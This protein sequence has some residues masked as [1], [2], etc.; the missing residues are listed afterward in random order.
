MTDEPF[1]AGAI[2]ALGEVLITRELARRPARAPDPAAEA[3]TLGTLARSLANEPAGS[4]RAVADAALLL[5]RAEAAVVEI[6]EQGFDGG[7][8]RR[9]AV[10]GAVRPPL[11]DRI[12]VEASR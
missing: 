10:A 2:D 1:D 5:C 12:P 3:R 11:T 8:V 6:G 7:S 4:L 9:V